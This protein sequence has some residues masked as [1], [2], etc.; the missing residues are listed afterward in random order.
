MRV[1]TAAVLSALALAG[2]ASAMDVGVVDDHGV[3]PANSSTFF[4]ALGAL[5]MRENRITITW[6]P[7]APTTIERQQALELYLPLASLR[8]IR[9]VSPGA[10]VYRVPMVASAFAHAERWATH[11]PLSRF[12]GF[13]VAVLRKGL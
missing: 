8:G 4:D 9:V 6:D 2:S 7:A 1:L 13:L 3:A 5:G 12:G 11:S 10:F